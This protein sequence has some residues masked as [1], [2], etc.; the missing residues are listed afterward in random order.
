MPAQKNA[1]FKTVPEHEMHLYIYEYKD[2][3]I[4]RLSV[5]IMVLALKLEK[6]TIYSHK[7]IQL[8]S[9]KYVVPISGH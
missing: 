2:N 4:K 7:S 5:S 1:A 6:G 3:E 9:T 8:S